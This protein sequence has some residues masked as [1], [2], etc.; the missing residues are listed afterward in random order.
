MCLNKPLV[1]I[2]VPLFNEEDNIRPLLEQVETAFQHLPEYR[3]ECLFVNDGSTDHTRHLLNQLAK[4]KPHLNPVHLTHNSGQ[5]AALMA[6]LHRA[7]GEYILTIDGDLQNDP[8][9]FPAFLE[10]LQHY[11]CVCG[12]RAH[13]KD[14][15][16]RRISS[17]VAN[18][19]RNAILRDGI[20]DTGCGA[21][22]FRRHCI[23]HLV[24]F[25]G[26]HRYFAVF[27]RLAGCSITEIPVSH[28]P[29]IHGISKYGMRNRLWRGI[30]DLL[31]VTWLSYRVVPLQVEGEAH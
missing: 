23:R 12:Y 25:N 13:R 6:G 1:S 5:S 29:R 20:R 2:V 27:M 21:K 31:G 4:D 24:L 9:D 26:M 22:G 28:H 14:S 11:D 8:A 18:T 16:L 15:L 17:R 10:A 30:Y 3:Y 19:V 7:Q